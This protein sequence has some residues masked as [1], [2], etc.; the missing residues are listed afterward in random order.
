M[1]TS[2]IKTLKGSDRTVRSVTEKLDLEAAVDLAAN[3]GPCIKE[4]SGAGQFMRSCDWPLPLNL[5][6]SK[7]LNPGR[8]SGKELRHEFAGI[9]EPFA[10]LTPFSVVDSCNLREGRREPRERLLLTV[11][12]SAQSHE[13]CFR[14]ASFVHLPCPGSRG[15][16]R[17]RRAVI[18]L[19]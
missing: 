4:I 17:M 1:S 2:L 10:R 15:H 5:N 12:V 18:H 7:G 9:R 8:G 14:I 6:P 16:L 19:S 11:F 3:G 13:V